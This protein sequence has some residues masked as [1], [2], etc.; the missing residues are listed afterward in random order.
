M[1]RDAAFLHPCSHVNGKYTSNNCV[2]C[3]G[4]NFY[5]DI[6]LTQNGSPLEVTGVNKTVQGLTHLLLTEENT[7]TDYGYPEYGSKVFRFVGTKNLVEN[8]LKFQVI[9]DIQ[10]FNSIKNTQ[11]LSFGNLTSD[12]L[13]RQI[14]GVQ[15][16]NTADEQAVSLSLLIGDSDTLQF[17]K[18]SQFTV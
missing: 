17:F 3:Q 5:F 9:R 14:I 13:I 1:S 10:Y 16:T 8:R 12:E 4:T 11:H 2:V 6:V 18:V 15:T 7:Y